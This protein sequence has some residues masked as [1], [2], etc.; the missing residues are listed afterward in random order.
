MAVFGRDS[1]TRG[2]E[3]FAVAFGL[4]A[5]IAPFGVRGDGKI[6]IRWPLTGIGGSERVPGTLVFIAVMLGSTSD[7]RIGLPQQAVLNAEEPYHEP[8]RLLLIVESPRAGIDVLVQRHPI[9]Q[10]FYHNRWM[11][12]I[13]L[14]PEEVRTLLERTRE[15]LLGEATQQLVRA[16]V[17][18]EELQGQPLHHL[19]AELGQ[20]RRQNRD[21][22]EHGDG[23]AGRAAGP[24]GGPAH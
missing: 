13:A 6:V 15:I 9:L 21:R 10:R 4:L 23:H 2:G 7:L 3:G 14:E 17:I 8:M 22:A 18:A 12:L 11:H 16:A 19:V 20:D 1:W 5:R 24:I